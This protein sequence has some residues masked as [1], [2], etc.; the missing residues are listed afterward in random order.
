[1]KGLF[2]IIIFAIVLLSCS[3]LNLRKEIPTTTLGANSPVVIDLEN[4]PTFKMDEYKE[5]IK[6]ENKQYQ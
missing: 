4:I 1:M 5:T 3:T 6:Q 2:K